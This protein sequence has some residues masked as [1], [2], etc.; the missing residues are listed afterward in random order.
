MAVKN[1]KKRPRVLV[2]SSNNNRLIIS[3]QKSKTP[4][5]KIFGKL[6]PIKESEIP[7]YEESGF[8]IEWI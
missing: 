2:R 4:H 1:I 7:I 5:V 3:E 8:K 6:T